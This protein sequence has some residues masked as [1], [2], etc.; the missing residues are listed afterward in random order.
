MASRHSTRSVVSGKTASGQARP[1]KPRPDFPLCWHQSGYWCKKIRGRI[2]YFGSRG[3]TPAEAEEH[4][5][6]VRDDLFAGRQPRDDRNGFTVRM[7]A[8]HF[9]TDRQNRVDARELADRT[10]KQY[11]E[12]A[13]RLISALGPNRLVDDLRPDDFNAMRAKMV[14]RWSPASVSGE[15][16]RVRSLFKYCHDAGLIDR[17]VLF[18]PTFR[19]PS[20]KLLRLERQRKGKKLFT[21]EQIHVLTNAAGEQLRCM[22]LLAI[23]TG[24][25]NAD[26]ARLEFRHLDLDNGWLD[27]P[28]QK[29]GVERRCRLWSET[30]AALREAI[31]KRREPKREA[32]QDR[33][34]IT[35][36][37]QSWE[38]KGGGCPISQE[39]AKLKRA[40]KIDVPGSFYSLRHTFATV[41][42]GC[43]D[44]VAVNACMGHADAHISA[45]YRELIEDSRLAGVS[46]HVGRWLFG[47]RDDG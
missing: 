19:R 42:G 44:Q 23:N 33:V 5:A 9:L 36:R 7:A 12:T 26:C 24:C 41:A 4:Y 11:Y 39:F 35:Q 10:F 15:V 16:Q 14:E 45:E 43:R 37:G 34:F 38:P 2:Y 47:G 3:G 27:F 28:R 8:N 21:A 18:G 22:I 25:G 40:S 6:R 31:S 20:K 29:T 46:D 13:A 1:K 32:F 30:I 17:P